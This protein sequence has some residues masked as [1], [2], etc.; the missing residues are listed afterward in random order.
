MISCHFRSEGVE[1]GETDQFGF[2]S[3]VKKGTISGRIIFGIQPIG[4][5]FH[6]IFFTDALFL[7]LL[8]ILRSS[9]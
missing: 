8:L 6:W 7:Y 5:V 9:L 1:L 2:D 3:G 4:S